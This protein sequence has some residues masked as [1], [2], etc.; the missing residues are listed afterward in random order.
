LSPSISIF[1]KPSQNST[2][3]VYLPKIR[4]FSRNEDSVQWLGDCISEM[5]G[6]GGPGARMKHVYFSRCLE[7]AAYNWYCNVLEY[8]PKVY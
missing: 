1:G 5:E 4:K 7:G 8:D 6:S 2:M 3:A